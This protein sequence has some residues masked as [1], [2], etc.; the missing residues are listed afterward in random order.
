MVIL[1]EEKTD[2]AIEGTIIDI[3]TIG[4]FTEYREL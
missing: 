4:D 1:H 2:R 3:E